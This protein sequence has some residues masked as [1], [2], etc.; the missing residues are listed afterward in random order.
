MER[1]HRCSFLAPRLKG[2]LIGDA[3]DLTNLDAASNLV[4]GVDFRSVYGSLLRDWFAMPQSEVDQLFG[5]AY[6]VL[7][8]FN[9]SLATDTQQETVQP[10]KMALESV[11]PESDEH[12]WESRAQSGISWARFH[13]SS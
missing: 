12:Q 5:G 11:Y 6:P 1:Q 7:N 4:A 8:L 3:P 13:F 9:G 10:S 2:G